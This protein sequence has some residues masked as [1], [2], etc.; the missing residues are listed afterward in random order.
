MRNDDDDDDEDDGDDDDDDVDDDDDDGDDDGDDNVDDDDDG[1]DEANMFS[2]SYWTITPK[3][4]F[5]KIAS[6]FEVQTSLKFE[7]TITLS[8]DYFLMQ[9]YLAPDTAKACSMTIQKSLHCTVTVDRPRALDTRRVQ[10]G[11]PM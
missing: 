7:N 6:V 1:D 3:L 8:I 11:Y 4:G 9:R 2:G 10:L 5:V